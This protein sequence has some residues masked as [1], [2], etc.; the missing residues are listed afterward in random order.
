MAAR[1]ESHSFPGKRSSSKVVLSNADPK[2]TY[3]NLVPDGELPSDYKADIEA[4]KI[5][6]P[7]MKIN[8]AVTELPPFTCLEGHDQSQ[9]VTG[10]LFIAPSIDYMQRACDE[11]RQGHPAERTLPQHPPAIGASTTRWRPEGKHAIS[12]FS[13]YFPYKLAD[14]TWDERRDEI[15]DRVIDTFA[16]YAPNVPASVIA[17]Q[18]LV[19]ARHRGPLRPDRAAHLPGR[20]R[21]G[22]SLRYATRPRIVLVRRTDWRPLP[23]RRGRLAGRLRDGRTRAQR[24]PRGHRPVQ[25]YSVMGV[26][27]ALFD[28]RYLRNLSS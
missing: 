28:V 5:E 7:V 11:A 18:V 26:R 24:R 19:A 16:K 20:A 1:P 12:I 25:R 27:R 2:R 21:T 17:R 14:G 8:L 10:G 9:G 22:A 23:L 4:I 13:Q 6:S 15:A 3:L